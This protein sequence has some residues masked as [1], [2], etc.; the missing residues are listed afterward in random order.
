[1][2]SFLREETEI[3]LLGSSPESSRPLQSTGSAMRFG[4][5]RPLVRVRKDLVDPTPHHRPT[6]EGELA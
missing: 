1:M 6:N 3:P 2:A 5:Q 4:I